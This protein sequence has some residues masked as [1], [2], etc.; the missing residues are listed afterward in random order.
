MAS[1][2][3]RAVSAFWLS[4]YR[5]LPTTPGKCVFCGREGL[6]KEHIFPDWLKQIFPKNANQKHEHWASARGFERPRSVPQR[7][8]DRIGQ[9]SILAKKVRVVCERHCNNG[10]LSELESRTK[11]LLSSVILGEIINI[12]GNQQ[13][14]L[15]TWIAKTTMTAENH[16]PGDAVIPQ[17]HRDFLMNNLAPPDD[18]IIWIAYYHVAARHRP[19]F[20]RIAAITANCRG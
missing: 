5:S 9:G 8:V 13:R 19:Q 1:F 11:Q 17:E 2:M 16:Y 4:R 12:D 15:A 6:S 3:R 20:G 14:L 10:W 7:G 18:W